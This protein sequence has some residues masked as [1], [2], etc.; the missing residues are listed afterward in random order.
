MSAK[1]TREPL[2]DV[3]AAQP[4]AQ[5]DGLAWT[6]LLAA[7]VAVAALVAHR[8]AL[9]AKAL[10]FD[11]QQ[12]LVENYLVQ[13]PGWESTRRFLTEVL[14]PSTVGGYYQ[15]LAMISLML[16]CAM[17][18][19]PK[20]L[21][22]FHRTSLAL[23]MANA[24]LVVLLLS[25]LMGRPWP[26]ALS[27]LL[28]AV[29]P[30]TVEPIPWVGERKTVLATF[31]ALA[32]LIAYVVYA[33]RKELKTRGPGP[34]TGAGAYYGASVAAFVLALMSKPTTT[35]LPLAML[36]MDAWPLRRLRWRTVLEKVPFLLIAAASSVITFL[37][38][39]RTAAVRMPG[40]YSP[41]RIPLVLCHNVVFYLEKMIWPAKLS[42]HY[43]FPEPLTLSEARMLA[44][45]IGT[46]L[47]LAALALSWRRTRALAVGWLI[48]FV[49]ILPTMQIVGFSDV[50]AS[51]KYA[52]LPAVGLLM[53]LAWALGHAIDALA[54]RWNRRNA[55][56]S[57]AAACAV[58]AAL[59]ARGTRRY[60]A[61]WQTTE[62]LYAHMLRL[63]P[64]AAPLHF[65][66]GF[67]LATRSQMNEAAAE[68]KRALDLGFQT[69]ELYSNYG[70]AL[71]KLGRP[72]EAVRYLTEAA[73]LKPKNSSIRNNLAQ[74]LIAQGRADQAFE[75]LR[76]AL[77]AK[78]DSPNALYNMGSYLVG[79]GR[80]AEA[81]QYLRRAIGIKPDMHEAHCRLGDALVAVGRGA[82]AVEHYRQAIR[83]EPGYAEA[84]NNL[85]A[86]LLRQNRVD[87]AIGAA[88]A[89]LRADPGLAKAHYNLGIAFFAKRQIPAAVEHY[90][91]A[92]RIRPEFPEARQNLGTLLLQ[93]G[94]F[95]SA[96]AELAE[97]VRLKPD[98]LD[99]RLNLA[100]ALVHADRPAEAVAQYR[101]AI[102]RTPDAVAALYE[103]AWILAMNPGLAVAGEPGAVELAERLCKLTENRRPD[104]LDVLAAAYAA[105]G[106]YPEAVQSARRAMD[107]AAAAGNS[108]LAQE[109]QSRLTL[110]EAG[111]PPSESP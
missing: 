15:P 67:D 68:F 101:E 51:D 47:L 38:Q 63:A 111:R 73:K 56:L 76:R 42:S 11:D 6:A 48:F 103:L 39:A 93:S 70:A 17:G 46:I 33:K 105:A 50:I 99:A 82:E 14:E 2:T 29:H 83:I 107:L 94:N 3:L 90:R 66:L 19:S 52:Y 71:L 27:G 44:G 92:I 106:R 110:Y 45:V 37:S 18:G 77:E 28:F 78:P 69:P 31:F 55:L 79:G 61:E 9:S 10:S 89:A 100:R 85:A 32:S 75:E 86:E 25:L 53:I 91:Q 88:Q 23:H 8:P 7:G 104:A 43:P 74:A 49:M 80:P 34:R 13:K 5:R 95:T 54:A 1:R 59:F 58:V 36:L 97:A 65:G 57:V 30:L 108:G 62:R 26:A 98:L 81:V 102:R 24:M 64:N 4:A 21:A 16:D 20:N 35:P 87:E 109:I 96:V 72:D 40:E 60:L 41:W 22:P 12:Y 84:R